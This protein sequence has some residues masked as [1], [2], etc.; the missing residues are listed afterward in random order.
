MEDHSLLMVVTLV[1]ALG[2]KSLGYHQKRM[3]I[4]AAKEE[5]I[6]NL[7]INVMRS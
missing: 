3:D 2:L 6:D 1:G 5:R 4:K 7:S